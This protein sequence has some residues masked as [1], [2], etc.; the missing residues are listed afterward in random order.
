MGNEGAGKLNVSICI[1]AHNEQDTLKNLFEDIN[2]QDY[3]HELIE[4][5]L[6]DSAS[7]DNTKSIM[8]KFAKEQHGFKQVFITDN[9]KKSLAAGWNVALSTVLGQII[10]KIDAHASVPSDF[11]SKNVKCILSGED[12]CG[13]YRPN[14]IDEYTPW[15]ETLLIAE[16]SMFGSSIAPYRRNNTEKYVKSMFHAAYKREVFEDVGGFNELLGRTEDNEIHY[17]IRRAGYKLFFDSEIVSYQHT[18]NS[19]KK[20]I[21]QKYGNGYWVGLTLGISPKCLSVFHFVPLFFILA[22]ISSFIVSVFSSN[23]PALILW[24]VYWILAIFMTIIAVIK[25]KKCIQQLLLPIIFFLLH[26]S[27]GLGTLIGII[28]LPSWTYVNRE[29]NGVEEIKETMKNNRRQAL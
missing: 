13:G 23:I 22:I 19:M 24:I 1:I 21:N 12:I 25:E 10:I 16:K 3:P 6:V 15:K 8:Q 5:I 11:V 27:Y 20:L 28:K 18:R 14:I 29:V 4:I 17:R 7:T 2:K 9:P 26:I